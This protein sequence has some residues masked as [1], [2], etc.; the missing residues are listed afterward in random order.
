[1]KDLNEI[2]EN[3]LIDVWSKAFLRAPAQI[4]WPHESDSELIAIPGD[5][6]RC[7][8]V[9]TDAI[10]EE[11][12]LGFYKDPF[13]MG[14]M[15]I[16][17][18]V[19]D[20]AAVGA[21]PLGLVISVAIESDRP[22]EFSS[23]IAEGMEA[24]CRR[25]GVHI[26]GGDTNT[27]ESLVLS[28]TAMGIV[29]RSGAMTRTGCNPGDVL[30]VTGGIG[31]GNALILSQ[32]ADLPIELFSE[33][34]FRPVAQIGIG[35]ILGEFASSC[36]DTSDG[37]LATLDQLM[38]LNRCGFHLEAGWGDI[39]DPAAH[40]ICEVT[41]THPW[42]MAAGP[43]G[44]FQL[45]F[46]VPP[47]RIPE[48]QVAMRNHGLAPIRLG[49]VK[50]R[51]SITARADSGERIEVDTGAV[52]NLFAHVDGEIQGYLSELVQLGVSWGLTTRNCREEVTQEG[53][54][55]N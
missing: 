49:R 48:F 53:T 34:D 16:A 23:R 17:A 4:N 42:L 26:L 45:V 1:M 35:R 2:R 8:A 52:R 21:D 29:S 43:H 31:A 20:L 12:A 32:L 18:S 39:L 55:I 51:D 33:Y 30:F 15:T 11:I 40:R 19:S 36:M 54:S 44:E 9:T 22:V 25:L 27:S 41:R 10:S 28:A 50:E 47:L 5:S 6:D 38:R 37:L 7:L 13:T 3:V 46:T 14:W 24:A